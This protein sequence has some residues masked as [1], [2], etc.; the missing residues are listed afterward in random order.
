MLSHLF[1]P[2]VWA[3]VPF[4][5]W[6]VVFFVFGCVVGSFLNVCIHR[7]PLGE[8]IVSPPSHC[9]HCKYS[10]PWFLNIPLVT[11]L[12]L[13]GR[14]R[15][16]GEAISARYFLVELL[17]GVAF[18]GC[19]LRCGPQSAWVAVI[20]SIFLAGLIVATFIDFEYLII[21]DEITIGGTVAGFVLSFLVPA[22]HRQSSLAGAMKESL[23]G[24]ALGAGVFYL[25]LRGGKLAFGRHRLSLPAETKI[26]FTETAVTLPDKTI[27]YEEVFSRQSDTITV[28]ASTVELVDR[29]YRDVVVRLSPSRL[30]IGDEE[31]NPEEVLVLE[32]TSAEIVLPREAMG[33]GDVKF[34]AA[35]GAFLGWQAVVFSV[36]VS[37]FIGAA[38]GITMVLTGR[39]ALSSRL[40][41]GPYIAMAATLWIFAG[42]ELVGWYIQLMMHLGGRR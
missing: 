4:H 26:V 24:A 37:A 13:R 9:P 21:P 40:P 19:W 15:N 35:I 10:I 11:W 14:C 32:A 20:Y 22:L 1:D 33:L 2:A 12:Y 28:R 6:S 42:P 30:R 17:T 39:R 25:I 3:A 16:C 31:L 29:C 18:L 36:A 34:M 7:M 5:F 38:V 27:P 41:Y 8:S 23:F